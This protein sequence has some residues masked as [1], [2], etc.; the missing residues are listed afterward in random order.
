MKA[1]YYFHAK[2]NSILHSWI[3]PLKL[4][5]LGGYPFILNEKTTSQCE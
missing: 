4:N 5:S 1:K 3:A 2:L